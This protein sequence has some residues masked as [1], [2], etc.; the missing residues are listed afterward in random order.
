MALDSDV[1]KLIIQYL[2]PTDL[3]MPETAAILVHIL[4]QNKDA[5]AFFI[6]TGIV[7]LNGCNSWI[8]IMKEMALL[9]DVFAHSDYDAL[10]VKNK[11]IRHILAQKLER[12]GFPK[13]NIEPLE[14][15]MAAIG[16]KL[17]FPLS[18]KEIIKRLLL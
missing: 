12:M 6:K 14:Y 3:R 11:V 2:K 7:Y 13:G 8:L 1:K 15:S 4:E 18:Q 9:Y 16:V 10:F 17:K 5:R